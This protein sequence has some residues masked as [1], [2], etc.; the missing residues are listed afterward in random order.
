MTGVQ[1]CALPILDNAVDPDRGHVFIT[2]SPSD[3]EI[4]KAVRAVVEHAGVFEEIHE[5]DA[6]SVISSHCG[7]NTIGVLYM[8]R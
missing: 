6:G 2:H 5:T 3:P 8:E 4:V 7:P 1:T